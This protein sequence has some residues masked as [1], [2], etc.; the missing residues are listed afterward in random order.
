MSLNDEKE[1]I[2]NK[3]YISNEKIKIIYLGKELQTSK[4]DFNFFVKSIPNNKFK[5]TKLAVKNKNE[6][7][8]VEDLSLRSSWTYNENLNVY[9]D[10]IDD[11]DYDDLKFKL[12]KYEKNDFFKLH[13]DHKGTHTCLIMGGNEFKGGIL[14]LKNGIFEIKINP[15]EMKNGYYMI[16][17]SIDFLHEVSPI[18]EGIRYIL[19]TTLYEEFEKEDD[20]V[21]D[22]KYDIEDCNSEEEIE[23]GGPCLLDGLYMMSDEDY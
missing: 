18:I 5:R 1:N 3:Y 9:H 21:Y 22:S 10:E 11:L 15:E 2:Q 20:N 17:F 19:K 23:I 16:I 14:T 4:G 13:K 6:T 8:S 12:L 7:K